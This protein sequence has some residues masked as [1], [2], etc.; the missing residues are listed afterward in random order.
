MYFDTIFIHTAALFNIRD[1]F[2]QKVAHFTIANE[3][4]RSMIYSGVIKICGWGG[5]SPREM[6]SNAIA[7]SSPVTNL[8]FH[9]NYL[10]DITK[11]LL[12]SH[13]VFR[14]ERT[15]DYETVDLF[16]SYLTD[17]ELIRK[18]SYID[19]VENSISCSEKRLGHLAA[20]GFFPTLN[21]EKVEEKY[22]DIIYHS[23]LMSWINHINQSI[24][25]I[26]S[27]IPGFEQHN[28]QHKIDINNKFIRSFLYSPRIFSGFLKN[29]F[30]AQEY[31]RI[32]L[33]P[34][35]Q[36]NNLRNGDWQK[37]C[38][39]YHIAIESISNSIFH[40]DDYAIPVLCPENEL[41][42]AKYIWEILN[43]Q[44]DGF[45]VST[46]IEGLAS[47]S[48]VL[49]NIPILGPIFRTSVAL[50]RRRINLI[51]RDAFDHNK[52]AISPYIRKIRKYLNIQ[53]G[54]T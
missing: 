2:L 11:I 13:I 25:G 32:F 1:P 29:F 51:F 39:A 33:V 26:Y 12:P 30:N 15:P 38:E 20:I 14:S 36:I 4:F 31:S 7:F 8:R 42:W 37:F 24:P 16:R 18:P 43:V 6:F 21:L 34:F 53:M 45:D 22:Q 50:M 28:I 40:I 48:G 54:T 41:E 52:N 5:K 44:K 27:Y 23:F 10:T 3:N 17:T 19:L 35:E 49:L 47:V 46:F 9:K